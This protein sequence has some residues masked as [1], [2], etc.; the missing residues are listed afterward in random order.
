VWYLKE[1]TKMFQVIDALGYVHD[2]Y[3]TFLDE[4]GD[5]QFILCDNSGRFF[6]TDHI[7]GFYKLHKE[8]DL[9]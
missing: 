6:K 3:G 5:I 2:A 1:V 9:K 7:E 8:A 4:D